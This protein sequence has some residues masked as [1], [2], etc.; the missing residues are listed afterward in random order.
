MSDGSGRERL[1]KERL[2]K[3]ARMYAM[4]QKAEMPEPDLQVSLA[5]AAFEEMP[6]PEA[7]AFVRTNRANLEDMA[8]A[9]KNSDSPEEFE[10]KLRERVAAMSQRSRKP[11]SR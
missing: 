9:L 5:L 2:V 6:L 11:G 1:H 3:T 8:W 7:T 10:V 4:C